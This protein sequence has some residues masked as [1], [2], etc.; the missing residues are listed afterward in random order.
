MSGLLQQKFLDPDEEFTPMPFWFWN[1]D[2]THDEIKR[3]IHDFNEKGVKGFVLHPRIGIPKEIEYLSD[4]FMNYVQTAV[5]EAELHGMSVIL[6]DEAMYPSGAAKGFVVKENPAY[7]SRGLKML[8]YKTCEELSIPIHLEDGET[9]VS[10][11]AGKKINDRKI[12]LTSCHIIHPHG[13]RINFIPPD[14]DEWTVFVFI[15]TFTQGTIRGIHFGED[16][17]EENAPRSADLLN[18]AAVKTFIQ[19]THDAYYHKLKRYFGKTVIAFFT[20]EPEIM[21]RGATPGLKPWTSDFLIQFVQNGNQETDLPALWL[22]ASERTIEIHKNYQQAVHNVLI[23]VYYKQI[24]QWCEEHGIALTGHPAASDD[25]GLLRFFHIPGQDVVWRWVG[26]ENGTAIEG[27]H[28]TAAKC[29]SDAARHRGRRRNLNEVLGVCGKETPWALSPGDMKWYLDWLLVRGVNLLVPHAFYYSVDGKR[30]SH[31]RPPDV[32]PNNLWWPYYKQFAQY[33]KRLSWLMTDSI[34]LTAVAILCEANRL[35]WKITKPL[36]ENQIEFNYLEEELLLSS[37]RVE[38]GRINIAKQT[39][40]VIVIEDPFQLSVEVKARLIDF[41]NGGGRVIVYSEDGAVEIILGATVITRPEEVVAEI[42]S[43]DRSEVVLT[44]ASKYIRVSKVVKDDCIF[45]VLVNE[46]EDT[47]QGAILTS[48]V[49]NVE[50]WD[51][52]DATITQVDVQMKGDQLL[53]PVTLERRS[54]VVF[55]VDPSESIKLGNDDPTKVVGHQI[56]HIEMNERWIARC[57]DKVMESLELES[58]VT[59]DGMEH[60]SGTVIYENTFNMEELRDVAKVFL[61]LGEVYE[62]AHVFINNN[63]VGIKMWAPYRFEVDRSLI[64][65]GLNTLRIE[66][67]N[68]K[69]NQMDDARLPSGLLGPVLLEAREAWGRF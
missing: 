13:N 40:N 25:I 3:Q 61:E 31:E 58:W 52:W 39:Y 27:H 29:S 32:G 46:G 16:D 22:D 59:W 7:A 66:V 35:P 69:A 56:K 30:R 2:L 34:N 43:C 67:T 57:D 18:P 41:I 63:E 45:Y 15:E 62:M 33:I 28:S 14:N 55:C 60:Y 20:D 11:Q 23:E 19:L 6:Y 51:P 42:P 65:N 10:V 68:S 4:S 47:Y 24:S 64:R 21:G 17:G 26:P 9:L 38:N 50:K 44:L 36:F 37:C 1:D 12:N 49:G 5:S 53:V 48:E 8:E 54:S